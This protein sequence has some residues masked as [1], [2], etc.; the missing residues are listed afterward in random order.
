MD[1]KKSCT[2]WQKFTLVP[3]AKH[4]ELSDTFFWSVAGELVLLL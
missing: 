4:V 3:S 2:N 1:V